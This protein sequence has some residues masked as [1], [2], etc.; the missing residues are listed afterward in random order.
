M[1]LTGALPTEQLFQTLQP[2]VVFLGSRNK[3]EREHVHKA[4]L[5]EDSEP[6]KD[7]CLNMSDIQ[8]CDW[9]SYFDYR[10]DNKFPAKPSS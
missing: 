5:G 4:A 10:K 6:Q 1:G 2:E 7:F 3:V 9:L 8:P